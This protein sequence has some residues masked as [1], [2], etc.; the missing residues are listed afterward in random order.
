MIERLYVGDDGLEATFI[1][2]GRRWARPGELLALLELD[3]TTDLARMVRTE[4]EYEM[5]SAPE[6]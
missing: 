4:I 6:Q 1:G 2:I 3:E 5:D